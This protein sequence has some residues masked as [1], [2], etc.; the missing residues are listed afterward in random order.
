M[1]YSLTAKL[2]LATGLLLVNGPLLAARPPASTAPIAQALT[3]DQQQKITQQA[4]KFVALL[5][6][7]N[8]SQALKLLSPDLQAYWTPES[9]QTI[10][11]RDLI[12]EAG[13]YQRVLRSS[14]IDV[15]NADIVRVS[16]QFQRRTEDILLTFNKQQA[17]VAVSWS[18]GQSIDAVVTDFINALVQKDYGKARGYL[19]PLLK[20][21]ILPTQIQG[22][23]EK[24][25]QTNG[26]FQKLTKIDI[27]PGGQ[28]GSPDVVIATIQFANRSQ[29]FFL[30]F[31]N[32]RRI[33]GVDFARE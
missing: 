6:Q 2:I 17:L 26:A 15:I 24:L 27:K 12:Q 28:L 19:S 11:Q 5:G 7:S 22:N 32:T 30:F 10:W 21:E 4:E 23:W 14:V 3:P 1:S 31:D 29:D 25:L 33:V 13:G 8:Y 18:S 20:T 9:L 16:V